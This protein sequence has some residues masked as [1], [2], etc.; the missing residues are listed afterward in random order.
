VIGAAGFGVMGGAGF[1]VIGGAGFGV[2]RGA[3]CA[4]VYVKQFIQSAPAAQ[5]PRIS[6]QRSLLFTIISLLT[7]A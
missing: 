7:F 4:E 3:G 6:R 5:A 2:T 1:G